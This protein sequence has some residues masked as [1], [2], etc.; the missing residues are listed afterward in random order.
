[1]DDRGKVDMVV[2]NRLKSKGINCETLNSGSLGCFLYWKG[3]ILDDPEPVAPEE[4]QPI[5]SRPVGQ[6]VSADAGPV[7]AAPSMNQPSV[8]SG[9]PD[10]SLGSG[11]DVSGGGDEKPPAVGTDGTEN[12]GMDAS[13]EEDTVFDNICEI[14]L[15]GEVIVEFN[16]DPSKPV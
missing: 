13:D 10:K 4:P 8:E 6:V 5:A 9:V 15:N 3:E 14:S 1:M 11:N 2:I 16:E 12:V 7:D